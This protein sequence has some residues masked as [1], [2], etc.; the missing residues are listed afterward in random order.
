M[1]ERLRVVRLGPQPPLRSQTLWHAIAHG[2][3]E[4]RVP[5]LSFLT[6]TAPYVSIGYHRRL[7]ELNLAACEARGLPVFRRMI[8]GGPVYLDQDQTFFQIS[9]PMSMLPVARPKAMRTLLEPAAAAFREVGIEAE[10]D[11]RG[12]ISV[13]EAKI[14]GIGGGQI[15]DAGIAVGNLVNR[16]DYE[17]MADILHLPAPEMRGE[18]V[19][20]MQRFFTPTPADPVRFCDALVSC[21]GEAFGTPEHGELTDHE[22]QVCDEMDERFVDPEWVRGPERPMVTARQVKI[23]SGVWVFA[24]DFDGTGVVGS[25]IEDRI[26]RLIISDP[27]MNGDA[28]TVAAALQGQPINEATAI[29]DG[30]GDAG[31][32]VARVLMTTDGRQV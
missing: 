6:P 15:E 24:G 23:R 21:Y 2:V 16:F 1:R 29:A 32:R 28:D 14:S 20:L 10:F 13:G 5:T 9:V 27:R 18:V 19:R 26:E 22:R 7:E 11:E 3:S 25:V 17:A 30:L 12:D 31:R 8:G 4:T